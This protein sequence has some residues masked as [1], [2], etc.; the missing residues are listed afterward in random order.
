MGCKLFT[1]NQNLTF[2]A[3]I[4]YIPKSKY[5]WKSIYF[6]EENR[7]SE[8]FWQILVTKIAE[9]AITNKLKV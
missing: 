2:Q 9:K 7:Y 6:K 5:F 8:K 4:F 3:F 1:L